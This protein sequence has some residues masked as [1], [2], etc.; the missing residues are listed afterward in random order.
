MVQDLGLGLSTILQ[1]W[2]AISNT[3]TAHPRGLRSAITLTA[4]QIWKERNAWVFNNNSSLLI[5]KIMDEGREWILAGP[6]H[7]VETIS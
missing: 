7:H 2:Q 5:Q 6:K 3:P 4:W 1:Y